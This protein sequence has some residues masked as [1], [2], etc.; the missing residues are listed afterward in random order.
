M[1]RGHAVWA[2]RGSSWRTVSLRHAEGQ[3]GSS[4]DRWAGEAVRVSG[5]RCR[6]HGLQ[7][8][9]PAQEGGPGAPGGFRGLLFLPASAHR[10]HHGHFRGV[11]ATGEP[12]LTTLLIRL[13][14]LPARWPRAWHL[15]ASPR[16]W[17]GQGW[18]G[19]GAGVGRPAWSGLDSGQTCAVSLGPVAASFPPAM[20]ARWGAE[21]SRS[22]GGQRFS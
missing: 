8:S 5:W 16:V 6:S 20:W 15:V 1:C 13:T 21:V 2:G 3:P 19:A 22:R 10:P 18:A 14:A 11:Q 12:P 4:G 7:V 9:P 17:P